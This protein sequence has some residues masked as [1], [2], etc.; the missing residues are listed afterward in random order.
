[1]TLEAAPFDLLDAHVALLGLLSEG[2]KHAWEIERQVK[3]RDMRFWTDLSQSSIYKH[4]RLLESAGY[5]SSREEA[6]DGRLRRV[7]M[8]TSDGRRALQVRLLDL[9]R[10][11]EH[12][13]WRLDLATYNLGLLPVEK[14][15]TALKAYRDKL[16]ESIRGYRELDEYLAGSGCAWHR[17]A[18]AR[19]P[20]AL[21][22]G[23]LRWVD[24]F[25]DEVRQGGPA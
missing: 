12:V 9:L 14:A 13:K 25:L 17:R 4:L 8:L 11:P 15:A 16:D 22:E 20:V 24:E 19:R 1:V 6:S 21:L 23:E 5:L 3:H 7:Y 18:V 2:E 10:E